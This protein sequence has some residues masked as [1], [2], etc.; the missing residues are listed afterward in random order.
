[1]N[2]NMK[3]LLFASLLTGFINCSSGTVYVCDSKNATKYHLKENCRGLNNCKHQIIKI[4][5]EKAKQSGRTLCGW[6]K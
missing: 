5:I 1:M 2:P 6:E 3:L 4:D